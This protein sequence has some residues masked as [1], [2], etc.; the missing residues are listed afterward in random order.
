[1]LNK[2]A[3]GREVGARAN[4]KDGQARVLWQPEL[5]AARLAFEDGD[6][7][8]I[9]ADRLAEDWL[10]DRGEHIRAEAA[11]CDAR[12]GGRGRVV[13]DNREAEMHLARVGRRRV[14]NRIEARRKGRQYVE[15]RREVGRALE[16]A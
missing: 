15:E 3:E 5:V 2:A 1:M 13:L 14:C 9:A 4:H 11:A 16:A 6:L 7:D 8:R 10:A 12:A